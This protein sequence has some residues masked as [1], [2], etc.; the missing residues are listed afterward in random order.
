MN[1]QVTSSTHFITALDFGPIMYVAS[2]WFGMH[3][4]HVR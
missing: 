1:G 3:Q 2:G 4:S